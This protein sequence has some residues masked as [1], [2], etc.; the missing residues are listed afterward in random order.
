MY[1]LGQAQAKFGWQV[2]ARPSADSKLRGEFGVEEEW[3]KE[4][5]KC[6][7]I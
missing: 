3:K 5:R 1:L 7:E 2:S 4:G 6:F